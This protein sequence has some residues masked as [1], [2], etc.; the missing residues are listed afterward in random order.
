MFS[1]CK[2]TAEVCESLCHG[3]NVCDKLEK[4][5]YKHSSKNKYSR[6]SHKG[7]EEIRAESGWR[8]QEAGRTPMDTDELR[9]VVSDTEGRHACIKV[10]IA[11][12]II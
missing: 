10:G 2:Q 5:P 3:E 4:K 1:D 6:N 7:M 11:S 8:D 12:A 9:N